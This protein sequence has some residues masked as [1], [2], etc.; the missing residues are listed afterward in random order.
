MGIRGVGMSAGVLGGGL[1]EVGYVRVCHRH[2]VQFHQKNHVSKL[3][4]VDLWS[5]G[6]DSLEPATMMSFVLRSMSCEVATLPS[7]SR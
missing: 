4:P 6:T 3:N 1:E 5:Q 2:M 7:R